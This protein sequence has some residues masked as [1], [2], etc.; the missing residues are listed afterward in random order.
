MVSELIDIEGIGPKTLTLLNKLGIYTA[1]D[2]INYYP[3]RYEIVRRSDMSEVS[4]GAK[5]IVDGV[6]EGQ[7]T[8]INIS[9]KLKK[10]IIR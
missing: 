8:I 9:N 5:V 10:I 2:L 6:I 4:D 1:D 7:P 3:Y